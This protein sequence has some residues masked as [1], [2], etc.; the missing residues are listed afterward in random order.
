MWKLFKIFLAFY[1]IF[2][3]SSAD[4]SKPM[5]PMLLDAPFLAAQSRGKLDNAEVNE[6]S[7]LVASRS[8]PNALWTHNDSGD[9][10]RIFLIDDKAKYLATFTITGAENRDWEDISMCNDNGI[11]YLYVGD[12]GDNSATNDIKTIY[13]FPEPD[14]S[15]INLPTENIINQVQVIR[16]RYPDGK[17]DAECLMIDPQTKDILIISKRE[18][19]VNVYVAPYPQSFEEVITLTKV[20]N[21]PFGQVVA[22]DISPDGKEILLKSYTKVFYWKKEANESI[23]D[24]LKKPFQNLPYSKDNEVQGESIA[25]KLDS[26]GYFTLSENP[27]N[28]P[29][30]LFFY[31]RK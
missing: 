6:A 19:N 15:T 27:L 1:F 28:I 5:P 25:W 4:R 8:N 7:G 14:V 20:A 21:L 11:S 12:I 30:D 9:K 2:S 31:Q 29:T 24:V 16:F 13:R 10:A 23:V 22:G 3:C 26:S 18:D 17:R